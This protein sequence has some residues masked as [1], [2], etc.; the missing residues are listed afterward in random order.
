M[1]FLRR[2]NRAATEDYSSWM[3]DVTE[4][5]PATDPAPDAAPAS[6]QPSVSRTSEGH[7]AAAKKALSA[8]KTRRESATTGS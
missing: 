7:L 2:K 3:S 5:A 8:A 4:S 6:A 1:S